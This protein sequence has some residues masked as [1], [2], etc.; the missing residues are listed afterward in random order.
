[1]EQYHRGDIVLVRFPLITDFTKYKERPALV[2]QNDIGNRYSR[3]LILASISSK[4]PE[5]RYPTHLFV[6]KNDTETGLHKDSIVQFE[7]ILTIPKRLVI[8]KL[9]VIPENY[10]HSIDSSIMI[11]LGIIKQYK[12]T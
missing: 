6:S 1:M 3:N 10:F 12:A 9:G 5:K 2:I 4:V 7:N 11:S 8:R